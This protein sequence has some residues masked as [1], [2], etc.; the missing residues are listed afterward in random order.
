MLNLPSR[1]IVRSDRLDLFVPPHGKILA[2]RLLDTLVCFKVEPNL[3]KIELFKIGTDDTELLAS[4]RPTVSLGFFRSR[5]RRSL[6]LCHYIDIMTIDTTPIIAGNLASCFPVMT[7]RPT[8]K[9]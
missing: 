5:L 2:K 9:L 8:T 6:L 4:S 1:D 7:F 3:R